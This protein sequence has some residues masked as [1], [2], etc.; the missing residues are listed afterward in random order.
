MPIG[1]WNND[2]KDGFFTRLLRQDSEMLFFRE[3]NVWHREV[4]KGDTELAA[5]Y[6]TSDSGAVQVL[7]RHTNGHTRYVPPEPGDGRERE[8]RT[9]L[10][11]TWTECKIIRDFV[12]PDW[13]S[14]RKFEPSAEYIAGVFQRS[15]AEVAKAI[16][17]VRGGGVNSLF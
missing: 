6:A 9:G 14:E 3:L 16:A 10:P 13:E 11:F 2:D 5:D 4:D 7:R 8:D 12:I 1:K 15:V 17:R